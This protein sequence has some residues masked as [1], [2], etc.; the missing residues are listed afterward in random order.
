MKI[1]FLEFWGK[2]KFNNWAGNWTEIL[3][4]M[5]YS[6]LCNEKNSMR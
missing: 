2:E 4:G 3:Y 1:K 5:E 6:D